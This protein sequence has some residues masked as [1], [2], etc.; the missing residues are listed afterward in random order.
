MNREE[1]KKNIKNICLFSLGLAIVITSIILVS[2]LRND[3]FAK[4]KIHLPFV[5]DY[6]EN[7]IDKLN[8]RNENDEIIKEDI[9]EEIIE[10]VGDDQIIIKEEIK[11][12]IEKEDELMDSY[13][14]FD[15][16]KETVMNSD[17]NERGFKRLLILL[18]SIYLKGYQSA[19][20]MVYNLFNA[21][22]F[23]K[24]PTFIQTF[25]IFLYKSLLIDKCIDSIGLIFTLYLYIS[26]FIISI[27]VSVILY[28]V[29]KINYL[30]KTT[31]ITDYKSTDNKENNNQ[32]QHHQCND[33]ECQS[34]CKR[35][36]IET[37]D[38]K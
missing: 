23:D 38:N 35:R 21:I 7:Q 8:R 2:P 17:N 15:S 25:F 11:K 26:L 18:K 30:T 24:L 22:P 36:N 14:F 28:D 13:E 5:N 9:S 20:N 4:I 16:L 19:N 1:D 31:V 29:I 6:Y 12:D 3:L 32:C 34:T 33:K 10:V 27:I 37:N